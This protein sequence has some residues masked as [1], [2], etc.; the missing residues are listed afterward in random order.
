MNK[1]HLFTDSQC[2]HGSA[3][4]H[5]LHRLCEKLEKLKDIFGWNSNDD[6]DTI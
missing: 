4:G 2:T 3:I 5:G 6:D 1:D